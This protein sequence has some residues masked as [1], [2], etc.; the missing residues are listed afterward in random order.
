MCVCP[1]PI[2]SKRA[3]Y[4]QWNISASEG[5]DRRTD[6]QTDRR[7]EIDK[8]MCIPMNSTA[9]GISVYCMGD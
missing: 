1:R 4:R 3:Y 8:S 5:R 2:S 9:F 6:R 7:E